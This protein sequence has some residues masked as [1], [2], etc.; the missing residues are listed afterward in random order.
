MD[1]ELENQRLRARVAYLEQFEQKYEQLEQ[2][3]EQL[4]QQLEQTN[5][6]LEQS[7]QITRNTTFSEYLENCHRLLF[8][9][10][11][12]N[13]DAAGGSITR[14]DGKSY[15][16]SL[17]PWTEFKELQ[18]QQ[19]DITKNILKDEPLFPSLHAIHTIQ[20]LACET[21]VANEEDIKL[22]E[23]IAVEGR[24]AEVIH[25]LHRKAEANSSVANLG[26]FRILFRNHS[27]TVNLPLEEVVR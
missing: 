11:R 25:T 24:V 10:F 26:V 1:S 12:V 18:Q 2:K 14:V 19:F 22:F 15:P 6:Q 5:E 13:P 21:P 8:Q 3:Y 4:G 27:L 17:R 7:Q 23:H 9:H 16:L 20:R